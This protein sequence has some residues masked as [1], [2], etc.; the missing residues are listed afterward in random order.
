MVTAKT[1]IPGLDEITGGGIPVGQTV[2]VSGTAG[3]GKTILA[4]QFAYMGVT[5]YKEPAVYLTFEET[6]ESISKNAL[7][8]G[9]DFRP[10]EKSQSFAFVKYDPY[11]V[12]EI[13][14]NLESKV[15]EIEAKRVVIDTIS[16][17]AMY[18]RDRSEYRRMVFN[19]SQVL[20]RL[21]CTSLLLGEVTPGSK[22]LSKYGV[23][24]FVADAVIVLYYSRME[25]SFTRAIQVWK[26]RGVNHSEKLH[27][28]KIG[29]K[30]IV[31]YPKEEAFMEL[32]S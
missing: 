18:L 6:P 10:I 1:G 23:V 13:I 7:N 30:G 20:Q 17:L 24:E 5:K 32:K 9:W 15:R 16:A 27:P 21:E 19:I 28:Y 29:S 3:A 25:S 4:C 8:F 26:M 22:E 14:T 11:H 12:D 31:V 2:L